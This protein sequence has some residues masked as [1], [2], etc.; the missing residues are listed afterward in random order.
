MKAKPQPEPACEC[1]SRRAYATCCGPLHAGVPA[2][3][4]EALM[5]SRY[6][7]YVRRLEAYLLATWDANHRPAVLD[8]EADETRWLGLKIHRHERTG[9]TA[10]IVE[11]VARFGL[12]GGRAQRLHEISRF[13]REEGRWFYVDGEVLEPAPAPRDPIS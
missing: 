8:L 6:C 11:F 1:G 12:G 4:A 13:R 10:A 3:D 2:A 5:R 7:A 9:E